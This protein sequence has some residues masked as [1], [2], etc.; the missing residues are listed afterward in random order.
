MSRTQ[1]RL[2]RGLDALLGRTPPAATTID[3]RIPAE[4]AAG[5]PQASASS[6]GV[7]VREIPLEQIVPNPR[8]PRTVFDEAALHE[9][10][11]SIRANGV[12]QPVLLRQIAEGRYELI[13][14]ER[15]VRASRMAGLAAVPAIVRTTSDSESFELA[16]VENIQR[17]DLNALE[18][19]TAYQSY[20]DAFGI[21]PEQLAVRLGESR[22]TV[23]NHLRLLAL[24]GEIRQMLAKGELSMG[25]ARAIA[26]IGDP[27]RQLAIALMSARRNLSVRQV[28]ALVQQEGRARTEA[29]PRAAATPVHIAA[30]ERSLSRTLGVPTRVQAGRRANSGKII[31]NYRSLEEFER[32]TEKLGI[33]PESV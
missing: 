31:V 27:E 6:S 13:A 26:A 10:T 22:S 20:L 29:R 3:D 18:R 32:I 21:S 17:S 9:L 11:T 1:Q 5:E 16:L 23:A 19:A 4:P 30:I 8:Q 33:P 14:G 2:G 7:M 12:L 25:H 15:R 24:P 28:E